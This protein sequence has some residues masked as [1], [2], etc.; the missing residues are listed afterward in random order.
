MHR[1]EMVV[2]VSLYA[3]LLPFILA[4]ARH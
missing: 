1:I 3:L 2:L 4:L